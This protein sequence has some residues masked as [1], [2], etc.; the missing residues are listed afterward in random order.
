MASLGWLW[1]WCF[2]ALR[3][4]S[5]WGWRSF[6]PEGLKSSGRGGRCWPR[7]R[8]KEIGWGKDPPWEETASHLMRICQRQWCINIPL[9]S[10]KT[11][12]A[13]WYFLDRA[14][15]SPSASAQSKSQAATQQ[16]L[17]KHLAV[18]CNPK[19]CAKCRYSRRWC[20]V[21]WWQP[22]GW[23]GWDWPGLRLCNRFSFFSCGGIR[24]PR[25]P[26]SWNQAEERHCTTCY[27]SIEIPVIFGPRSWSVWV[28]FR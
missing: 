14:Y 22:A 27:V 6:G 13:G 15:W 7:W 16:T 2:R 8:S 5:L 11:G 1:C 25:G 4:A 10:S 9:K 28:C 18:G 3:R 23:V 19:N 12:S 26:L 17:S 21:G 20:R 24:P